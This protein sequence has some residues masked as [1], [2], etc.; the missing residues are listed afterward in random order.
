MTE[1]KAFAKCTRCATYSNQLSQ[2]KL[3][4]DKVGMDQII[5]ERDEHFEEQEEQ[6]K[7]KQYN[8]TLAM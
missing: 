8:D 2:R 6:R 7:L 4:G 1:Y 3:A 5:K